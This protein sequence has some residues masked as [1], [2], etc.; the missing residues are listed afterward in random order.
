MQEYYFIVFCILSAILG[1]CFGSFA[2]VL[3]NRIPKGE[4]IVRGQSHCPKCLSPIHAKDNI[5]IISFIIL[6]GKCRKCKTTISPHYIIVEL[7]VTVSWLLCALLSK[8]VGYAQSILNM[9]FIFCLIVVAIIDL[10]NLYIPD[11]FNLTILALAI[12]SIFLDN[13]VIWWENLLGLL[14]SLVFF[15]GTYFLS[16]LVLKREGLGFGDVKLTIV[17]G[18]FLG[19]KSTFV[20]SLIATVFGAMVLSIISLAQ[21]KKQKKLENASTQPD[22]QIEES[23]CEKADKKY[24]EYPFAPFLSFGFIVAVFVGDLLVNFYLGLF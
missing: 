1:A 18:L 24:K 17:C 13:G 7:L 2:T 22:N 12:I 8:N 23:D 9:A 16:K 15:G 4:S 20:A 10:E 14:F 5:P 6:R 21:N 3:I 11:R 19:F